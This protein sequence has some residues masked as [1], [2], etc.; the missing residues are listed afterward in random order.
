[1][2]FGS[3]EERVR[4]PSEGNDNPVCVVGQQAGAD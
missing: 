3:S 1:V 4:E 2:N